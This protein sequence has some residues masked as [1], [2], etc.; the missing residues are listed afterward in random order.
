[1]RAKLK[2]FLFEGKLKHME[3]NFSRQHSLNYLTIVIRKEEFD[4]KFYT[5]NQINLRK[6][7]CVC[8]ITTKISLK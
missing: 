7:Y 6:F 3:T 1:M 4:F 2:V 5:P 8:L